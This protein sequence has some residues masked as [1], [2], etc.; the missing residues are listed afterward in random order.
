MRVLILGMTG[1]LGN[2]AFRLFSEDPKH[3]VWGTL[4]DWGGRDLGRTVDQSRLINGV[5]AR[6]PDSLIAAMNRVRPQVVINCIGIIK[7]LAS[8]ND[9]LVAL[10]INAMF[11]HRAA[12]LCALMGS[13][14][15]HIS[16]DCVY[17]GRK[18]AY[19]ESDPADPEDLYGSSK[20]LGELHNDSHAI[21]L[22]TG[23]IGHERGS[24][25]SLVD[26]FL[27]QQGEVQGYSRAIYSGLP[28]IELARVIKDFVLPNPDMSGLYHVSAKPIA[29]LDLL[30]IIADVYGK[31]IR[32]VPND[33]MVIDRSLRSERFSQ[34][35]GYVAP[36]WPNL[37]D[38][39]HADRVNSA[40]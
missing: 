19:V 23:F 4:R 40:D 30:K 1:M 13:R 9:P 18:G 6:Y 22:R 35:T 29:K 20:Y 33:T 7:Q 28:A 27:A 26:W 31:T 3:E 14:L 17:S 21:T 16:T 8:A 24:S 25:R 12:S 32:I 10:P 11:P 2:A 39:M 37:I 36:E 38:L 34:A 5:D 15:V